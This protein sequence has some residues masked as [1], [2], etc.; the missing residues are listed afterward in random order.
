VL[1]VV[2]HLLG[3]HPAL[4]FVVIGAAGRRQQVELGFRYDLPDPPDAAVAAEIADHAVAVLTERRVSTVI[5]IGYG[6]GRLVTP[7]ADALAAAV[8]RS[9]LRLRELLRVEDGRYWSYLCGN[10]NCCPAEGTPFDYPSHPVAAAMTVAGLAAYPDRAA[11]ASTLAPPAGAAAQAMDQ[12]IERACTQAQALVGQAQQEGGGHPLRLAVNEGR[13]TVREAIRVYRAGGRIT[14]PDGFA[15]LL[16]GLV[17][18]AVRDDAWARMVPEHREA[19]LRLWADLVRRATGPWLPAPAA[20]LAFTAWQ[21]GD[22][23]LANVALDRALAADPDYSMAVL[24]REILAAGVPP[25]QARLPMTPEEVEA[26]YARSESL[27]ATRKPRPARSGPRRRPASNR[28]SG[29]PPQR[30]GAPADGT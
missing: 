13:R 16:V 14:D 24:L 28:P 2:P 11:L 20:L 6:P 3:F 9:R 18:L 26:S 5:G 25:S 12:A 4:S 8:R 22:G 19:H 17:N 23:T 21:A 1:A 7:V 30:G 15:R 10:V 29:P 27:P